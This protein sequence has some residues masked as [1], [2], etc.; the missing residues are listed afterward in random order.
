MRGSIAGEYGLQRQELAGAQAMQRHL[1]PGP[2]D[3]YNMQRMGQMAQNVPPA[4]QDM[5]QF[6]GAVSRQRQLYGRNVQPLENQLRYVM[7]ADNVLMSRAL[8]A[9]ADPAAI[10][11]DQVDLGQYIP[12]M[13]PADHQE[14]V[15]AFQK[16]MKEGES[17]MG[18]DFTTTV[19][20]RGGVDYLQGLVD[21]YWKGQ[22]LTDKQVQ[23]IFRTIHDLGESASRRYERAYEQEERSNRGLS[24]P[25]DMVAAEKLGWKRPTMSYNLY[26]QSDQPSVVNANGNPE[27]PGM[28]DRL[29]R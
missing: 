26:T 11:S 3:M 13:T 20:N 16:M 27:V 6:G 17:V 25:M 18:D 19:N 24:V 23:D 9:G 21:K 5:N 4:Y 22:A 1:T 10:A 2:M 28:W 7:D 15:V 29:F 12:T 8:Q 14:M